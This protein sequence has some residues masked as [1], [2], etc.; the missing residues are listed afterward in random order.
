MRTG[1]KVSFSD[2]KISDLRPGDE[3]AGWLAPVVKIKRSG[4]HY[5]VSSHDGPIGIYP[6]DLK[7]K[8]K[9]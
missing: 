9:A 2:K 4:D 7:V 3:V 6:G 8:V 1:K 5:A